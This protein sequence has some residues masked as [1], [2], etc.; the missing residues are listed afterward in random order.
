MLSL[1]YLKSILFVKKLPEIDG[2]NTEN[3][4]LSPSILVHLK[5][6]KPIEG[7]SQFGGRFEGKPNQH[8]IL[9]DKG[10]H[11]RFGR[12]EISNNQYVFYLTEI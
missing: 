7:L 2:I 8:E 1:N 10:L 3:C 11:V 12:V 5:P 9:F 4:H 6:G